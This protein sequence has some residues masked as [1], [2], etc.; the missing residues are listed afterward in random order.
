MTRLFIHPEDFPEVKEC[1]IDIEQLSALMNEHRRKIRL[2]LRMPALSFVM[3]S[4]YE[5]SHGV[6]LVFCF[7]NVMCGSL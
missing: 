1:M 2:V 3:V 6:T 7:S 5:V 4:G